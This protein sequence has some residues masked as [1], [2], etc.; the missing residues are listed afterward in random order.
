[1]EMKCPCGYTYEEG[2]DFDG[3]GEWKVLKGDKEFKLLSGHGLAFEPEPW[4]PPS[5]VSLW[6]CPKCGTIKA[7][8]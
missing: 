1:M 3:D 8:T 5:K 2:I 7:T 4:C 6:V